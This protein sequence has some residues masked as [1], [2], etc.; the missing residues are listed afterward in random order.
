MGGKGRRGGAG[1]GEGGRGM[2]HG[3]PTGRWPRAIQKKHRLLTVL[4]FK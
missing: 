3:G 4:C 1:R 2:G